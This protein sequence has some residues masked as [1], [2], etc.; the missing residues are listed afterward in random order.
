MKPPPRTRK[1]PERNLMPDPVR[2]PSGKLTCKWK[3]LEKK[4]LLDA[5]RRL[6]KTAGSRGDIDYTFLRKQVPNR[7]IEEI[8]AVVDSLKNKV[9]S[10]VSLKLKKKRLEEEKTRKPIDVWIHMASS[11][12]GTLEEQITGAFSQMMIVS[13][14]EP[15]TLKNCDPPQVHRPPTDR[16]RPVGRTIPFRPVPGMPVQGKHPGTNPTRP[17][18]VLKTP[19]PTIGPAKRPPALSRVVRVPNSTVPPPQQQP[20]TTSESSPAAP[21]NQ[22][23]A[24]EIPAA[25]PT[26]PKPEIPASGQ[27]TLSP[28][29]AAVPP[30]PPPPPPPAPTSTPAPTPASTSAPAST[31]PPP[32][33]Q[34]PPSPHPASTSTQPPPPP[35]AAQFSV[36]SSSSSTSTTH[37]LPPLSG[38]AAEVHARFG[39]TSK[40]ATKDSP[41]TLG[42]KC[43]VDFER[44]YRYLSAIHKPTDECHLTPMES[45]IMLDLLMSLPEELPLLDCKN[46]HKHLVQVYQSLSSPA[47]SQLARELFKNLKG[48]PSAQ[49]EG[50]SG[51]DSTTPEGQQ[52]SDRTGGSEVVDSGGRKLQPEAESQSSQSNNTSSQ[53][54]NGDVMGP[55]PPLNPFMVPLKLLMRR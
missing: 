10:S 42:V 35:H 29:S 23:G 11:L 55:C 51:P 28:G 32:P 7:S 38:P 20:S 5:L 53:S 1:I 31:Q 18:L 22:P 36:P 33:P 45:A 49:S 27:S 40:F 47:D 15:S 37:P 25:S 4:K 39:R 24:A 19:A 6:S 46:L 34:P 14:T 43:I 13:S 52:S 8:Q 41:R 30:P 26:A 12:A 16:D 9:I 48:G 54:G 17:L 3:K 44:I 50:P 21:S 2:T